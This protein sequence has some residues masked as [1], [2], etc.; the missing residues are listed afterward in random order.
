MTIHSRFL[1][2]LILVVVSAR[3]ACGQESEEGDEVGRT[4]F[5]VGV[6]SSHRRS[7]EIYRSEYGQQLIAFQEP[8]LLQPEYESK[9]TYRFLFQPAWGHADVVRVEA[10]EEEVSIE[11]KELPVSAYYEKFGTL[12]SSNKRAL[13]ANE[14]SLVV[15]GVEEMEFWETTVVEDRRGMDGALW[16]LEGRKGD[17]Y[18]AIS[19]WNPPDGPFKAFCQLLLKLARDGAP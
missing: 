17:D 14:W 3:L 12:P 9:E 11:R 10:S 16:M 6:F 15:S 8:S 13:T 1:A 19:R 2:L 5:P 18:K 7:D 4:Y